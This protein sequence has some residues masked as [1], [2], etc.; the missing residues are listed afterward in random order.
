MALDAVANAIVAFK[1]PVYERVARE[2]GPLAQKLANS[3]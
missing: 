3:G 1:R 2:F